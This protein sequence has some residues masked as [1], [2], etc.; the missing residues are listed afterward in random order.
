MSNKQL[1]VLGTACQSPTRDRNHNGYYL[2]WENKG[3]LFDPGEGTQRQ[4]I[5][6]EVSAAKIH[7][8]LISHFHGDH[9]LGLPGVIQRLSQDRIPHPVRI[10]FP[11]SGIQYLHNLRNASVFDDS[12]EIIECPISEPGIAYHDDIFQI[13]CFQLDHNIDSI[14]FRISES[15]G[16]TLI[17]S[18]LEEYGI[19]KEQVTTLLRDSEVEVQGKTVKLEEVSNFK[20][21]QSVAYSLDTKICSALHPLVKDV[22]L[23]LCEATFLDQD[24]QKAEDYG[25]LTAT[26]AATLARD[27]GVKQLALTH[28]SKRY[29]TTAKTLKEAKA[30]HPDTVV[31]KDGDKITLPTQK[32]FLSYYCD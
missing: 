23:L 6:F 12:V 22:D 29:G 7:H 26:Q 30:I 9:C 1:I 15:D 8:I 2:R 13:E 27:N 11:A 25:H 16:C 14:G 20:A 10:Y 5:R 32:R 31:L 18:K 17:P 24:R 4:M 19:Q 21:G 28:I 3:L